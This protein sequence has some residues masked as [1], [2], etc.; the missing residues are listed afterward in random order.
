MKQQ[1]DDLEKKLDLVN[2]VIIRRKVELEYERMGPPEKEK[3][4]LGWFWNSG[5][6]KETKP[7]SSEICKY[8]LRY[9]KIQKYVLIN[10][11]T[12]QEFENAMTS[13]EKE[14]L[15]KAIDY[16]EN[17]TNVTYPEEYVATSC[18]FV[19]H[20]LEI[21]VK[22]DTT[23]TLVLNMQLNSVNCSVD[24]RPAASAMK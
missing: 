18:K 12:V 24:L 15:Y 22:D 20:Q 14:R 19:L 16:Q 8:L 13:A 10:F 21:Q 1:L 7:E 5:S 6:S 11:F 2:L 4:W 3:S 17:A 9:V 23:M